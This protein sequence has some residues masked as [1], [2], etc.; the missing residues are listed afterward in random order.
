[1]RV[2]RCNSLSQHVHPPEMV[3]EDAPEL[4]GLEDTAV[5]GCQPTLEGH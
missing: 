1:M 5:V 2:S 4:I 3:I